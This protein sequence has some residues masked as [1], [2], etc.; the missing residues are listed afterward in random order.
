[1]NTPEGRKLFTP[2]MSGSAH[3]QTEAGLM[4]RPEPTA[5]QA[6]SSPSCAA[7]A[8]L[9]P[10]RSSILSTSEEERLILRALHAESP[11]DFR[12]AIDLLID[13]TERELLQKSGGNG[14]WLQW[15][16]ILDRVVR[17]RL[18]RRLAELIGWKPEGLA[19]VLEPAR[20]LTPRLSNDW[21]LW[22]SVST[23]T[24]VQNP[25]LTILAL[26]RFAYRLSAS[27]SCARW[28][29]RCGMSLWH[30]PRRP[31]EFHANLTMLTLLNW[32]KQLP[33]GSAGR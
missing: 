14:L 5:T 19:E 28:A 9:Q 26:C 18:P 21:S 30:M 20:N 7:T 32:R 13:A 3:L 33:A 4:G 15:A 12:T 31:N 6:R 2:W 25:G 10:T 11:V 29:G 17:Q 27:K 22:H 24:S 23:W 1:M 16:A 8:I